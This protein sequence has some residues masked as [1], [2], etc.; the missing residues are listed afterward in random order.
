MT[1]DWIK[2]KI[3]R[4]WHW[5]LVVVFGFTI[6]YGGVVIDDSSLRV[7]INIGTD[8]ATTV[9]ASRIIDFQE[10]G[11][12]IKIAFYTDEVP[13]LHDGEDLSR[14][15]PHKWVQTSGISNGGYELGVPFIDEEGNKVV[16]EYHNISSNARWRHSIGSR[17][18]EDWRIINYA[19]TTRADFERSIAAPVVSVRRTLF[20]EWA[21][22]GTKTALAQEFT[23]DPDPETDSFDGKCNDNSTT[24]WD[25]TRNITTSCTSPVDTGN[26]RGGAHND[27]GT[28][29]TIERSIL[30]F[31]T[32]SLSGTVSSSSLQ[33]FVSALL[34]GDDDAQAYVGVGTSSPAIKTAMANTDYDEVHHIQ[35]ATVAILSN[36]HFLSGISTS[37]TTTI[38]IA[39]STTAL[40]IATGADTFKDCPDG[41]AVAGL[42]CLSLFEG[43]D[44]EDSEPTANATP[45]RFQTNSSEEANPPILE[46]VMVVAAATG[47]QNVII[48]Q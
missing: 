23:S 28:S 25:D 43:H 31:D 36:I 47:F 35:N 17:D 30:L 9:R 38:D 27:S 44:F 29:W 6:A 16:N 13:T 12:T 8:T 18:L 24:S 41:T 39:A 10:R 33:F 3:K 15:E 11:N 21:F 45:N 7:P 37:A 26:L 42:T 20:K 40:I 1:I 19:T 2:D 22:L 48:I 14:R 32:S 4:F 34:N 5:F 46:V